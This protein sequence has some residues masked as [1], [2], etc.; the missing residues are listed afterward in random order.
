MQE[1]KSILPCTVHDQQYTQAVDL[2]ESGSVRLAIPILKSM[3][4]DDNTDAKKIQLDPTLRNVLIK[5]SIKLATAYRIL[6][7]PKE[8]K[9]TLDQVLH[10]NSRLYINYGHNLFGEL[11]IIFA[12][13]KDDLASQKIR[14]IQQIISET[15]F[16]SLYLGKF[17][18]ALMLLQAALCEINDPALLSWQSLKQLY[19]EVL[20][21]KV[22]CHLTLRSLPE[23]ESVLKILRASERSLSLTF[24][25]PNMLESLFNDVPSVYNDTIAF[26]PECCYQTLC[27]PPYSSIETIQSSFR[28]LS[29][30]LHPDKGG[31]TGLMQR[32]RHDFLL[33]EIMKFK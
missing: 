3:L 14:K 1:K 4:L 32:V 20:L 11:A 2:L 24:N 26:F 29:K 33:H 18:G 13:V 23:A 15:E 5:A 16:K 10:P 7:L 30:I 25:N 8:A 22:C 9:M 12:S 31:D 17:A 21:D 27:V 19:I 6:S 28:T